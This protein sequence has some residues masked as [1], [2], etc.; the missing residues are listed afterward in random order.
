MKKILLNP[1]QIVTVN[2]NG[3]NIKR[4]KTLNDIYPLE[5]H[6]VII[7]D[8]F[9]QDIV[10]NNSIKNFSE[11][12]VIDASGKVVLPGLIDCHTHT[13]FTGS[14]A[15]EFKQKLSGTGYEEIAKKGGGINTTVQ[16]V[17]EASFEKLVA[18]I[19]PRI[20]YFISNGITTLEIKSGYGLN[21]ENELKLLKVINYFKDI[22]PIEIVPTFLGA[23]TFPIEYKDNHPAYINILTNKLLPEIAENNYAEFCDGF[24]EST[25]FTSEEI[26]EVFAAADRL[27]FRVK[28]HTEQFNNIGGLETAL[29]FNAVS[30]DHLEVFKLSQLN[31]LQNSDT[32]CVLLPGVSFF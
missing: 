3:E 21:Y 2:T 31:L 18:E 17:R 7:E 27:G 22:S 10:P 24:C 28:L 12:E 9:I 23:H 30:I 29:K 11:F 25:A 16:A 13:A 4:G 15:N 5:N 1:S 20:D 32:V 26:D 19:G 8:D 14:R 6:S